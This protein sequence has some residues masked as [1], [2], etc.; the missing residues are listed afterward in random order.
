MWQQ[1]RNGGTWYGEFHNRA[2]DGSLYWERATIGSLRNE[3]GEVSHYIA[4]KEVITEEKEAAEKLRLASAVFSAAAEA[5]MVTDADNRIQ[6]VNESFHRITGYDEEE[7]LGL[8]PSLL[9]SGKHDDEF[10][11]SLYSTLKSHHYWEGEIW[12]RRKNGQLYPQWLTISSRYDQAGELEGYVCLFSDITKRKN[13]EAIIIRQA[14]FDALTGLPNRNLFSDR[15]SQAVR[16]SS[17]EHSQVALM[18][19]D[20]DRFKYVNDTF[21]HFTGDLLLKQVAERLAECVR[22]SDTVARLGGDEFAV[23]VPQLNSV[24]VVDRI[25]DKILCS[26]E[27]PYNLNGHE[28]FISCS[29]GIALYPDNGEEFESLVLHADAA[30]YK[31]K[32]RGRNTKEY[33]SSEL[34]ETSLL[35]SQMEKEIF[36]ALELDQFFLVY[37]P[38]WSTD[39]ARIEASEALLRWRHPEKGLVSPADFIP[40]AEETGCIHSIGEWVLE[41]SCRFARDLHRTQ[42]FCPTVSVN[43]SSLQF[44]RGGIAEQLALMLQR[45]ELPGESLLLEITESLLLMDEEIVGKQFQALVAMGIRLAVDDFGTGY[46]SLSYLKKYPISRIKIDKSFINDLDHNEDDQALVSGLISMADSLAMEVIVEG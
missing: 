40:I 42:G 37:Q 22:K 11:Q 31:A 24:E 33:Y 20:L 43:V 8:N 44:Q 28:A 9:K 5:I 26:L 13:D 6:M 41:Q 34:N 19:I 27:K 29:I 3:Q 16:L 14:N 10:Y 36:R 21:G 30:M 4:L 17:R 46:S 2:R 39:G 32:A 45:Y 38:I 23:V 1:I 15:L 25:A 7:V 18:F 35:R 12:N